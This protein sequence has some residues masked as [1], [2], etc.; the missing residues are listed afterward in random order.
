[1]HN[2][3]LPAPESKSAGG[4]R[5]VSD[6]FGEFMSAFEAFKDVND[7]RIGEL[8]T[9]SGADV[10]TTEKLDRISAALD[11]H[12]RAIDRLSL[13][14]ARPGLGVEPNGQ[15]T[16]PEAKRA[17][18]AYVRRGDERGLLAL[19][20]KAMSVGVAA[21][22]GYL[23]P[24]E[25][26]TEIGK[27]LSNLSPIRA[28]ASVR[29]VSSSVLKKPFAS[30]GPATGWVAETAAR[31]QT[32]QGTLAELQF[33]TMELYAMPAATSALLDDAAVDVDRWLTSEIETAFAEQEG[34]AFINGDGITKPKGFLSYTTVLE[35]AWT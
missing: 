31:P 13:K 30:S 11:E 10:L 33:P 23:V 9:R 26:E 1:M 24:A 35:T 14:Q 8:E 22:G 7:Q 2:Q 18:D 17:F 34:A 16:S 12:K 28:I 29:Q 19:D 25:T 6:A 3:N 15:V 21:D 27:R 32:A 20:V 4:D 5:D